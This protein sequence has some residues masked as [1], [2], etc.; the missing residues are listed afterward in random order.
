MITE[1]WDVVVVHILIV[2]LRLC[3]RHLEILCSAK[4]NLD[5]NLLTRNDEVIKVVQSSITSSSNTDLD[6][7]A[8]ATDDQL[9]K[10]FETLLKLA[11]IDDGKP[12]QVIICR[13]ASKA[14]LYIFDVRT[15]SFIEK[16]S[17][18]H[19]HIMENKHSVFVEQLCKEL[20][21]NIV[22]LS[23]IETLCKGNADESEKNTAFKILYS[24]IDSCFKPSN[25]IKNEQQQQFKRILIVF[26]QLLLVRLVSE[27]KLKA[28]RNK[29]FDK[30]IPT[31]TVSSTVSSLVVKYIT[32]ILNNYVDKLITMNDLFNSMLAGL[33]LMTKTNEIFDFEIIQ[34]IFTTTMP[35]LVEYV[36][37]NANDETCENN[38]LHCICWLLGKMCNA[39]IAGSQLNLVERKHADKLK[40]SLFTGG[41]ER[42]IIENNKYLL[43][44]FESPLATYIQFKFT[45]GIEQ[46][47]FDRDF[48]MSIYNNT[49]QGA[50]LIAK[51]KEHIKD[52]QRLL[53]KSIEQQANDAV[54]A[55][56]A[57]YIKHYRRINLAKHEL[58]Q[59]DNKKPHD[60]LSSIYEYA[61]HVQTLFAT[62]KSQGGDCNELYKQ[63]KTN[64]LFLLSSVQESNSIPIIDEDLLQSTTSTQILTPVEH[65]TKPSFN[66]QVS[67]WTTAKRVLQLLR[68]TMNA[69]IRFKK[70][71]MAKRQAIR[72]KSDNESILNRT[73]DAYIY[74]DL[75]K[76][77]ISEEKQLE[78]NEL[79][80][81]MSRQYE[82]AMTRMITYQFVE[83]FIQKVFNIEDQNLS[84]TIL[85]IY[86]PCLKNTTLEWS[87]LENIEA[88]TCNLKEKIRNS[89]YAIIKVILSYVLRLATSKT[90]FLWSNM[91][92]LLNL[93]YELVDIDYLYRDQFVQT[94]FTFFVS[95]VEKSDY[96]VGLYRK[97]IGYNWFRLFILKLCENIELAE[98]KDAINKFLNRQ[99]EFVFNTLILNELKGLTQMVPIDTENE[100]TCVLNCKTNSLDNIAIGWFI[101]IATKTED[102]TSY[103]SN[104]LSSKF[105]IELCINQ[106]LILL[107]RLVHF[108]EHVQSVCATIDYIENLLYI[109][110]NYQNSVTG[111]LSLKILRYLIPKHANRESTSVI[112]NFLIEILFCIGNNVTLQQIP[113]YIITELISLY[114]IVMS[115]KSS[116]QIMATE[117]IFN[118]ITSSKEN[119]HLKSLETGD[120]TEINGLVASLC[121][122]GGYI[123][124]YCLGSIV[125]MYTDEESNEFQLATI[126]EIDTNASDSDLSDT[127][128]YLIQYLETERI[129]SVTIDKLQIEIDVPP[130]NLLLLSNVNEMN[131]AIHALF[132]ALAYFIQ[133]DT[134]INESIPL[135]QLKRR[136]VAV[137]YYILNDKILVN[138]FMQKPYASVIAKLSIS[139]SL[140][141]NCRHL[142]DLQLLTRQ[143]LEQYCLSLDTCR[144]SNEIVHNDDGNNSQLLH[145]VVVVNSKHKFSSYVWN[146][147]QISRNQLIVNALSTSVF[148][149]NGWK[150]YASDIEIESFKRGLIGSSEP[151]IV[152]MPLDTSDSRVFE[153]CGNNHKF[154]GR[155]SPS[156]ENTNGSF[157]TYVVD[158]VQVSEGKW[159]YCV[160][161]LVSGVIQIGW[162]TNG[163]APSPDEGRGIGDD[164][165]SWSYDGSRGT[166]YNDGEFHFTSDDIRWKA[167][168]ICGCGIE[169]DGENICIK[170]WL[171][172]NYLGVAFDHRSN[173]AS[174][175]TKCNM[176]P[177]GQQ[178]TTYFPGV[179]LQIRSFCRTRCELIFS[180]EDMTTCPLPKGYKPLLLPKLINLENSLVAYPYSAYLIDDQIQNNFH[181]L[182]SATS[183]TFLR[184]F[185]S[186]HHLETTFTM[187]DYQLVLPE[188]SNGLPL[189]IDNHASSLTISFDFKILRKVENDADKIL[190]I[191][192]ITLETTEIFSVQI[193]ISKLENEIRTAI[194]F[195][196][197]ERQ[198]IIYFGN[199][200]RKFHVTCEISNMA[201]LNFHILPN[202]A[203]GIKNLGMWKYALSEEHI[204]RLFTYGLFYV[205]IDYQQ[206]KEHRKQANTITFSKNQQRF[207]SQALVLFN[208]PFDENIWEKKKKQVDVDESKYFR[209]IAG[210]DESVVQLFGNKT[211]LVLDKSADQ[212]YEYT[213]ILDICIPNWPM[214]NEQLTLL[215]LDTQS[216]IYITHNGKIVLSSNGI[217]S[218]S[219]SA[220]KLNEYIRLHISF[221]KK[222]VK[223]YVNG[224]LEL[225]INRDKDQFIAKTKRFD[226][227][228]EVNLAKNTTS[229]DTLRIECKSI[230]FLNDSIADADNRKEIK[231]TKYLLETLIAPPFSVVAL[232]LVAIGYK[233]SWIKNTMK[234]YNTSNIQLIDTIIR[235]KKEEFLKNEAQNRQKRYFNI[236]SRLNP[237]IDR[238]KMEDL[239][240][241][242]TFDTDEQV[243]TAYELMLLHY[244]DL[245]ISKSS[246]KTDE[247]KENA[248]N[249]NEN[250][251]LFSSRK[252]YYETIRDLDVNDS[253]DEWIQGKTIMIQAEDLTNQL[254]DATKSEQE[255]TTMT[256]VVEGQQKKIKKSIN[257]S[258]QQI[259]QQEYMDLR[260]ACEHGL[261]MIYARCTVFNM[262]KVWSD[263]SSNKFP[264]EKLGDSAFITTLLQ[265]MDYNYTYTNTN[266]DENVDIMSLLTNSILKA[267]IKEL[268]KYTNKHNELNGEILHNEAPLIYELQKNITI[269]S[270]RFLFD[271]SLLLCD[272][273]NEAK[274]IDERT[275]IERSSLNFVVKILKLF[276]ELATDKSTMKHRDIDSLISVLF[277]VTLINL[278]F[279]LFLISPTNQLKIFILHLFST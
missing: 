238:E 160:K 48:L 65:K 236:L 116:W 164:K 119:F 21:K 169:I 134:S 126:I 120:I 76:T 237:S 20:T 158:N 40:S 80:Q 227:F 12:E 252:W 245:Q 38:N 95:F 264:W 8:F 189:S 155:I 17:F 216:Q 233:E 7:T 23:W 72:Q 175:T 67:R 144:N 172:G 10:W 199:E 222:F 234:Q 230:T 163:F 226:L 223:I 165:Y 46:S 101:K 201:K 22:L 64:A 277:P 278:L 249:S 81:C 276:V 258:H 14:L 53:Q 88:S 96:N 83:M 84:L 5:N 79:I 11:C 110:R 219:D 99:Q 34:P 106:W 202:I 111:F 108:Y 212:W 198:L 268:L 188:N 58:S 107:L 265:L 77:M 37:Q 147:D 161:V 166:L 214:N 139:D 85:S 254:F 224:L 41:C 138:I 118:T 204:R 42:I 218:K 229:D 19:K 225:S 121:I 9:Q 269:Q 196:T 30:G 36:V 152:P 242:S 232:N 203:V 109:Y 275:L 170:Y 35:M 70:L 176:L 25:E 145:D 273:D 49:N 193:S 55:V 15:S 50:Q 136:S 100:T 56:F 171:N 31:T 59:M 60:K 89:Y 156:R 271:P 200:C 39:M 132:D 75:Y 24:F 191:L 43:N 141:K 57:V 177:N 217:Q 114:R 207:L 142:S 133:I 260:I 52:R 244:H 90:K 93:P 256:S 130:P 208:E 44:L 250:E 51:M 247:I 239:L 69:C 18:I 63:I 213:L 45:D 102:D 78:S 184:D 97:L 183:T 150:P 240:M 248:T 182:R 115:V 180:P 154:K 148:K 187:D 117:L 94:L 29:E 26:Q 263:H 174:T 173:I 54:A 27:S 162:A 157:P 16:L 86:L 92:N 279:D 205:A 159:Y 185:V 153:G 128:T 267:E 190:D 266:T 32:H 209:T 146:N 33:C 211:Y 127:S 261:A 253:L 71:M 123:Q 272:C 124:F 255:L 103:V 66:R 251:S 2:C 210:T 73:I 113:S 74:G 246:L 28:N 179:T 231:S 87:Y 206:L 143:H 228:R 122:L 3:I 241:F 98:D 257:Y 131:A 243:T 270:I 195:D 167:N 186:E 235:E 178:G 68:N 215:T 259:S 13:Q 82:R 168:D 112:E 149:Y 181:T 194:V 62:T 192:L 262:L 47:C 105:D 1:T 274:I 197:N 125:K 61:S 140:S 129:E 4:S 151:S 137:L 135:L 220:L 104:S 221:Q 91:F 6:L